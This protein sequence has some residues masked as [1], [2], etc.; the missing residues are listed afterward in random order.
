MIFFVADG[1]G[2]FR[3]LVGWLAVRIWSSRFF[4][5]LSFVRCPLRKATANCQP[6]AAQRSSQVKQIKIIYQRNYQ[7]MD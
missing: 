4:V 1:F 2:F 6:P 7:F 3:W 5:W